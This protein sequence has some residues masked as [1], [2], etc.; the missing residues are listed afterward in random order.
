MEHLMGM[1]AARLAGAMALL[2]VA[3]G[4]ARAEEAMSGTFTATQACPAFQ[5]FRKA[6]NPGDVK[7]EPN[8]AYRLIAKNKRDATHYRIMVEGAQPV[9]RWVALACGSVASTGETAHET[10]APNAPAAAGDASGK[11]ATH[12]LA[13]SWEPEFCSEHADKS[14]C[15]ELTSNTFA[16][17]HLIL[18]GLWPQ[19]RGTQYCNVAPE[20]RQTDRNHDWNGLP[21]PE[22]SA[23]TLKR[24]SAVMPGVQSKLQRHEWIVHGTC[25]GGGA[26]A[27]FA[28]AASLAEAVSNS[29]VS[30]LFADNAGMSLSAEAIRAAFDEAF[31]A[32]AGA[33]VVVS[34]RGRGGDRKISELVISLA[35]DV[36]GSGEP[37][38][39]MLAAQPVAPGCPAGIVQPAH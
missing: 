12:V 34:C 2:I 5:S 38:A 8:K 25:F 17:S 22:M 11:R 26:D 32:G 6:T 24:L 10:P 28:R 35:G 30:K 21:E 7:L 3:A 9:E 37:G 14:E 19:P 4:A 15:R 16:G 1:F 18:H 27:Y 36:T 20:V 29:K 23:A 39:L 33:R 31:G 13:M